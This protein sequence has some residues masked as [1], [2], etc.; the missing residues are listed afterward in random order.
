M[1]VV[2]DKRDELAEIC[3]RY[4]VARLYVF[5]SA[6]TG[7]F[8]ETSSDIDFIVEFAGRQP[9]GSYADRYLGLAEELERLF[10]RPVDLVTEESVRNPYFRREV[11]AT[12]RL[13]YEQTREEA[14]VR[15]D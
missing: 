13:V 12:R 3:Q 5:G 8:A 4:G 10:G 15:R 1:D 7:G 11:D 2:R 14:A 9:T 6:V